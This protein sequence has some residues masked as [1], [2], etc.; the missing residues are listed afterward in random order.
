[1]AFLL[2]LIYFIISQL[3]QILFIRFE[4][5]SW[6]LQSMNTRIHRLWYIYFDIYRRYLSMYIV[7]MLSRYIMYIYNMYTFDHYNEKIVESRFR[8]DFCLMRFQDVKSFS[9][10]YMYLSFLSWTSAANDFRRILGYSLRCR[11]QSETSRR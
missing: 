11:N 3:L 4:Y 2:Y 1:L 9:S 6:F 7:C 10:L 5:K 8:N